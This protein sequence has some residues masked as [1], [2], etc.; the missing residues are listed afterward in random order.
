MTNSNMKYMDHY[1]FEKLDTEEIKK[2]K[3]QLDEDKINFETARKKTREKIENLFQKKELVNKMMVV[4]LLLNYLV[5]TIYLYQAEYQ[6][7]LVLKN[8]Y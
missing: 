8:H 4:M 1:G 5:N 3:E 2:Q 7:I 6:M